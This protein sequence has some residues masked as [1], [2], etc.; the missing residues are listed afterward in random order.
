MRYTRDSV[1]WGIRYGS[2]WMVQYAL[3]GTFSLGIHIDPKRRQADEGTFG[4]YV[5]L[6]LVF[7]ALSF[8]HNPAAA[9]NHSLMRPLW[10]AK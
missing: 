10:S 3:D 9:W 1:S 5:D 2:W 4:P 8:G 6:H 7:V